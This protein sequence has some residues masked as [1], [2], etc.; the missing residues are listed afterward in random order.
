VFGP[1][2]KFRIADGSPGGPVIIDY[3]AQSLIDMID[4]GMSPQA[5]A[6]QPHIANLNGPTILESDT[7]VDALAPDLTAMGHTIVLHELQ[8]GSHIIEHTK[9]GYIGG[10]DPRRDGNAVGD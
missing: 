8:S 6:A 5:A 10:A 7:P 3:T 2:G 9:R 4:D 1:D